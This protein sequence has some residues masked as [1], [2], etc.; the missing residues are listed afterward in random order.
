[1]PETFLKRHGICFDERY[2]R[3]LTRHVRA[4]VV[5]C[6]KARWLAC[7]RFGVTGRSDF[8]RGIQAS[9]WDAVRTIA[10]P[11]INRRATVVRP[12]GT[13]LSKMSKRTGSASLP[14]PDTKPIPKSQ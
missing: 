7:Y 11:A 13:K 9:L 1:M 4:S 10:N 6:V 14:S 12:S 5:T 3:I 8:G 2:N